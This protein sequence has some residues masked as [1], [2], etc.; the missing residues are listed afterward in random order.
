LTGQGGRE[1]EG[2]N[3]RLLPSAGLPRGLSQVII[4]V[5]TLLAGSHTHDVQHLHDTHYVHHG[6]QRDQRN[7]HTIPLGITQLTLA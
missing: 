3:E 7:Q 1:L 2:G 6:R 4:R 5:W